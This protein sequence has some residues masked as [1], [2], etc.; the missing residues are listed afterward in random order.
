MEN[1]KSRIS[2]IKRRVP[3][4]WVVAALIFLLAF[5]ATAWRLNRSPDIF[6]DEI[7][8]TRVGTRV[9]GEG[10][11]VWDSS[12]PFL[13][14]PPLYFVTE[15][16]FLLL[17][18]DP[19]EMMYTPGNIFAEV[20]HA[21]YLNAMFAG[22]TAA[23][24][25]L[26]GWRLRGSKA[27]LLLAVLFIFDPFALRINRRAMLETMAAFLALA[28]MAVVLTDRNAN[29]RPSTVRALIAGLLFGA[30][31]L[32]KELTLITLVAFVVFG[33]WETRRGG[34][35]YFFHMALTVF[36]ALV[37]YALYPLWTVT[38]G[39]F[40]A[41]LPVKLLLLE[42]V[43]GL[44]RI[45]GWNR[46]GVS[47]ADFLLPR[48]VDY[49]TTYL[50]FALGGIA[51][52]WL[53]L[54]HRHDRAARLM[55]LWG[56]VL[57]PFFAFTT[58]FGAANDQFFYF[59]VVP[60]T[61]LMGYT[62][63]VAPEGVALFLSRLGQTRP[64]AFITGN[65]AR[66][67]RNLALLFLLCFSMPFDLMRWWQ[68]YGVGA[69]DGYHQLAAYV[70]QN[71]P[72]GTPLNASGDNIKFEYF[73]PQYPITTANTPDKA[74]SQNVHYFVVVPKD[75]L[76]QYG[77]L[78]PDFAEWV[79]QHGKLVFATSDS[80]Y[81]IIAFYRVDY[82]SMVGPQPFDLRHFAH[83]QGGYV[84]GLVLAL[85]LW[86]LIVIGVI[87]WLERRQAARS[88]APA[89]GAAATGPMEAKHGHA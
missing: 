1:L 25:Y 83:A 72:L 17:T 68:L 30:A 44:V 21:R 36:V 20:Y 15:G 86:S 74:I 77:N 65:Q 45:T 76:L 52:A 46:P 49:G 48:L 57:Y 33:L 28:A 58:L 38:S 22:L 82:P 53:L 43:T 37:T 88:F 5:G 34:F 14:H 64:F 80:S 24:L 31:L 3:E 61:L 71:V 89:H 6:T 79:I 41:L 40:Q 12:E 7:I 35:V 85:G 23:A 18:S 26:I 29:N 87:F 67:L 13:V 51:T 59:L 10:A 32:T 4:Q 19:S 27:G 69:D 60:V 8:Y 78:T 55:G 62:I 66:K 2:T 63:I 54:L 9:A 70:Q 81:G 42:R 84:G 50:L 11:L 39:E 56:L 47:L 75:M 16:L 73:F